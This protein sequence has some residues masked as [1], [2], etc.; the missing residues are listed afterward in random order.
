MGKPKKSGDKSLY[1]QQNTKLKEEL[2]I[3]ENFQL[4]EKQKEIISRGLDRDTRCIWIDGLWG[5]SKSYLATLIALKLLSN[6]RVDQ[7]LYIRN[8]IESSSTGKI[9][10][11]K[12]EIA[13]KMAPYNEIFFNKLEELLP[14]Q[15]IDILEK[16]NRIKCLPL[17]FARGLSWNCKAVIVDE[18]ASLSED[19]ILLLLTRCGEFTRIF[20]IGDSINQNDIGSKSGFKKMFTLFSDEDSKSN[21]T[22]TYELKNESDILRSG[23]VRFV[24]RKVGKS[25]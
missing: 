17:G 8:P 9:G 12:G 5:T 4:T 25:K 15:N 1:I 21:G 13:E 7:I 20:L 3:K 14:R 19:D 10:F 11:I 24:M 18:A 2:D 6:K 22:F 23:F 16:E